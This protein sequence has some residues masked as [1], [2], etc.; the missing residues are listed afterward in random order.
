MPRYG[1]LTYAPFFGKS[2]PGNLLFDNLM[3][4]TFSALHQ[5]QWPRI[6][7]SLIYQVTH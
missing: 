4:L 6:A 3:G 2:V 1:N 7:G 5:G